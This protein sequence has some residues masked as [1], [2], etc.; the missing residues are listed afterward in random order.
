MLDF[1]WIL[2]LSIHIVTIVRRNTSAF[3][4]ISGNTSQNIFNVLLSKTV[5]SQIW[6]RYFWLKI[7]VATISMWMEYFVF[8]NSCFRFFGEPSIFFIGVLLNIYIVLFL[9]FKKI[10]IDFLIIQYSYQIFTNPFRDFQAST[11]SL[12]IANALDQLVDI[13]IKSLLSITKQATDKKSEQ[14]PIPK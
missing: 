5:Q 14:L 1:K 13:A 12:S 3:F 4:D 6:Q 10:N 2:S 11:A 7:V 8:C 9:A